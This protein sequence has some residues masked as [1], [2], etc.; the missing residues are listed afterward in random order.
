V[1]AREIYNLVKAAEAGFAG[2]VREA[3]DYQLLSNVSAD[4]LRS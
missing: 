2:P 3:L 1:T 4:S